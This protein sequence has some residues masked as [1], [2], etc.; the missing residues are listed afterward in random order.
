[1]AVYIGGIGRGAFGLGLHERD[2]RRGAL[3]NLH[4]AVGNRVV[5]AMAC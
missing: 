1:M 5:C 2:L 3:G 4:T